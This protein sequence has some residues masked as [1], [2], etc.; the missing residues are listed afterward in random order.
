MRLWAVALAFVVAACGGGGGGSSAPVSGPITKAPELRKDLLFGY[1]AGRAAGVLEVAG[2]ANLYWASDMGGPADQMA[3]LEQARAAGM[4]VVLSFPVYH[5][6]GP[7]ATEAEMRAWLKRIADA[8]LLERVAAIFPIDEPDTVRMGNRSDAEVTAQNGA[9]RRVMGEFPAL[10]ST[11]LG[12]IY[13]CDTGR[14]P[15]MTSYD[16]VGCDHYTSGCAVLSRYVD[17]LRAAMSPSQRLV[18]V[19]GGADPWRQDPACFE[20]YAHANQV[21]VAVIPFLWQTETDT[22]TTYIGIRDNPTRALYEAA[23]RKIK[24]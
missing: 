7:P 15:G 13:A 22:G 1:Y 3:A 18:L 4:R 9:L 21:V 6:Q 2:H 17:G 12:V 20:S 23:G 16:W 8:G 19:P 11:K 5:Y 24:Q 14:Q 10:A